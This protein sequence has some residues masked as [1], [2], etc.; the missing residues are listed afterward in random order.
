[1]TG[2]TY[3]GVVTYVGVPEPTA[4]GFVG[5]GGAMMMRRRRKVSAAG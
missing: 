5:L 3:N 1:V 2:S 4:L